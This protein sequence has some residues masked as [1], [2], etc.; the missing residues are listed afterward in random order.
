MTGLTR[1]DM[2]AGS[3]EIAVAG[4]ARPALAQGTTDGINAIAKT[5]GM[6][7]GSCVAWSPVGADAGS[8]A[9]PAYAAL[10]TRDCGILVPE[11]EFKWQ[12]LRPDAQRFDFSQ[13]DAMLAFAETHGLPMRGHT[14]L[15]HKTRF[16]PKWLNEHDFGSQPRRE[17]ERLLNE[18]ITAVC[19]RYSGR[20]ASYDVVNE[21]IDEETG[22]QRTTSL[23]NAFGDADAMVDLAF[24]TARAAA[25]GVELVYNDYMSWEPGNEAHRRGVLKLLEGF[26][27]RGVPVDALGVQ[28]HIG[29]HGEDSVAELVAK[30]EKPWRGF[31][32][33]VVAMGYRLAITEF[34]VNDKGL[35]RDIATRDQA[36]ADYAA[37]YLEIMFAYPQLRDVLAW[38]MCD[39][40]S[41]LQSFTPRADG[42]PLRPAP[43]DAQ[44]RPKPLYAAI[45]KQF[46]AAPA[47]TN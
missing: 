17:A 2:L 45:G 1:R 19:R 36:V 40:Y 25:P 9:N 43:Y 20:I 5:R 47:R 22:D 46:A 21:T 26:R 6:R 34:D 8:F 14:L 23:S 29:I 28:S 35:P 3:A 13:F 37:A 7:F 39:K 41:W 32:D 33:E 42:A 16:F 31:L 27:K 12:R 38:G 4:L 30:Q 10:L 18:H 24:H 44:F 15:W 11:N